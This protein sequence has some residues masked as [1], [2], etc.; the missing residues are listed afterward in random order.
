MVVK[1]S[2]KT[3]AKKSRKNQKIIIRNEKGKKSR[4]RKSKGMKGGRLTTNIPQSVVNLSRTLSSN[5]SR[6]Q[7]IYAGKLFPTSLDSNIFRTH[8]FGT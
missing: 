2:S 5:A 8:F 3:R 6:L 7:H 4:R 1:R